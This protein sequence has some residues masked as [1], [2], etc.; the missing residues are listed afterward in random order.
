MS[1]NNSEEEKSLNSISK[2]YSSSA[3]LDKHKKCNTSLDMNIINSSKR[4]ILL[5]AGKELITSSQ[6]YLTTDIQ[7]I[8]SLISY[9]IINLKHKGIKKNGHNLYDPYLIKVCKSEI[10]REK[11][12]LPNYKDI[13]QKINRE[14]GIAGEKYHEIDNYYKRL[15]NK[16][17]KKLENYIESLKNESK[18]KKER[19][20]KKD[21]EDKEKK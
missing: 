14:Y 3:K 19:K 18:I 8:N 4:N 1:R 10:F 7:R 20:F 13:I 21:D 17:D 12:N 5:N 15:I 9:S 16:T 2:K 11:K 6:K